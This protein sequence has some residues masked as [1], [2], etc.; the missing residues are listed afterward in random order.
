MSLEE[1]QGIPIKDKRRWSHKSGHLRH[2][3]LP[4]TIFW[5]YI[6]KGSEVV[7]SRID[8]LQIYLE[9]CELLT[10]KDTIKKDEIRV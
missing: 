2:Q 4:F 7:C 1:V 6:H 10:S 8:P 9:L 5:M 3:D